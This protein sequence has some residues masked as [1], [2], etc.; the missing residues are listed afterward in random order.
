MQGEVVAL[1]Q[2]SLV[3]KVRREKCSDRS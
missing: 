1:L 2:R 3:W